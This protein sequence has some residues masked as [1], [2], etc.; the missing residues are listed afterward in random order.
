MV[1]INKEY[2]IDGDLLKN[3]EIICNKNNINKSSFIEEKMT[4]YI[5][6]NIDID[7][8]SSYIKN[9][10]IS[11]DNKDMFKKEQEL[12]EKGEKD[13]KMG[14]LIS[15]LD[16][17]NMDESIENVKKIKF[18]DYIMKNLEEYSDSDSDIKD[19][20]EDIVK[21][22]GKEI[23]DNIIYLKLD[24]GESV[25]YSDFNKMYIK[26]PKPEEFFKPKINNTEGNDYI[27]K[28]HVDNTEYVLRNNEYI[29][30]NLDKLEKGN[31]YCFSFK[32]RDEDHTE[33]IPCEF[34]DRSRID[35]RPV[36]RI[37]YNLI[38]DYI[39]KDY[40]NKY[41]FKY[42]LK[43]L[44]IR[45]YDDPKNFRYKELVYIDLYNISCFI[46]KIEFKE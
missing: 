41:R 20:K 42:N 2:K 9:S 34:L 39:K 21:I 6:N 31:T 14:E 44:S 26:Q 4:E 36:F 15:R 33:S 29:S 22:I 12:K 46:E 25:K 13:N 18:I 23:I 10:I 5:F 38:S 17:F 28:L 16:K 43:S 45:K 40:N 30:N 32:L 35:N 27:F 8:E 37:K 1:K 24:N 11:E 3:F 7:P 19:S